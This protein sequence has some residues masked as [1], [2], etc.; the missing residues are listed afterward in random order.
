MAHQWKLNMT[1]NERDIEFDTLID[2]KYLEKH[3][4][5]VTKKNFLYFR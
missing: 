3:F 2:K 5:T 4:I 1:A